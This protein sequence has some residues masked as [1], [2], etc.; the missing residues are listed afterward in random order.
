MSSH[1]LNNIAICAP[2]GIAFY[3]HDI[4]LRFFPP[5]CLRAIVLNEVSLQKLDC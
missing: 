5:N 2:H 3:E 4:A 1:D